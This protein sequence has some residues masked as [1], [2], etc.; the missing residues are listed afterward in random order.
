[1]FRLIRPGT[2]E[3]LCRKTILNSSFLK[4]RFVYVAKKFG[5]IEKE[6]DHRFM[7]FNRLFDLHMGTPAYNEAVNKVLWDD[8]D[9]PNTEKVISMMTGGEIKIVS[10]KVTPIGLEGLT[11][12]KEL[13]QPIRAD[14]SILMAMKKRIDDETL[15]AT[16]LNC[17]SQWRFRVGDAP[18]RPTCHS[19]GGVMIA[20]LKEYERENVKLLRQKRLTAQE[21][22]EVLRMSRSANLVREQGK[23]AIF[24]MA[25]RGIGP[26]GASRI[27]RSIHVDEDDFLRDIMSAEILYAK[28]KRFWD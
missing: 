3:D 15:F 10:G 2:V 18:D 5:I 1:T 9:I 23:R 14:H 8:L 21:K 22:K 25:G 12:S 27:L 19:C 11:R 6:A 17:A 7:N 26:D 4:W 16:C 13:M 24:T 20:V 28:N